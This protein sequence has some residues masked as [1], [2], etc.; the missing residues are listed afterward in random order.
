MSRVG[1]KP[2]SV[3]QGVQ[4]TIDGRDIAVK[5]PKGSLSLRCDPRMKV[6]K[7]EQELVVNRPTDNKLDRSLH[8]LT[9]SLIANMVEGVSKGFVRKLEIEGVGYR[10]EM[11]G[12]TLSMNVGYSHTIT[13]DSPEGI[14]IQCPKPN[15]IVIEGSDKQLVGYSAARIRGFC[16]PEP[17]KGKGIRYAGE[18]VRRKAGKSAAK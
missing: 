12:R 6:E 11:K 9:R 7:Q 4:I 2:I 8:G 14:T 16:K 1:K 3:P 17:Y 5:G 18:R 13:F 10:A 15:Q